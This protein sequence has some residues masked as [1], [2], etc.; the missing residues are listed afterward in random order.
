MKIKTYPAAVEKSAV[1]LYLDGKNFSQVGKALAIDRHQVPHILNRH[2]VPL[3]GPFN[4]TKAEWAKLYEKTPK[5]FLMRT[6]RNMQSRVTGIQ[7][8]KAHLYLGLPILD[9]EDFYAWA[10]DNTA[11]WR[12]YKQWAATDYDRKLSPSI[13]RIDTT[14]GYTLDN[15]EWLT[16]SV[17]SSLGS[18]SPKR[19][20]VS[21]LI[22][23]FNHASA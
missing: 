21:S 13:N 18:S 10:W 8:K 19:K 14:K 6:Y 23:V 9:R 16:H 20:H 4:G 1:A 7:K 2:Q 22:E 5:G 17:N 15:I 3:R 11:F 12:L